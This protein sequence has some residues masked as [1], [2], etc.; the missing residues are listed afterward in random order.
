MRVI[1]MYMQPSELAAAWNINRDG[2]QLVIDMLLVGGCGRK[3]S[4][5]SPTTFHACAL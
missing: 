3:I 4:D 5:L 2:R 1:L